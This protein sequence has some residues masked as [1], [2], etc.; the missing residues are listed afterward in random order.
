M[1]SSTTGFDPDLIRRYDI[2]GPRYTSYPT[3]NLFRDDFPAGE[4]A[5]ALQRLP[6]DARLSLYLH[7]PFCATVCYYCACNKIITNNRRHAV[8]YLERLHREMA[9]ARA[10]IPAGHSVEQLHF[11]GGTPTYLTDPQFTALF[12]SLREHFNLL[13]TPQRDFSIEI[14]PRTVD[15]QRI[16]FL[17]GLGINRVSLGIQDFDPDVQ[18]AVNR[19]QSVAD[20]RA[21]IDAARRSGVESVSVDLIYGLPLQS[22]ASFA[23]TLASV[24]DLAPDRISLYSYAHLPQRFKTQ[25]QINVLDLPRAEIK[26]QLLQLAIDTLG[27]AGYEY[28][29]MDHF[30]RKDDSLVAAAQRGELQRNFQGY[31]THRHCDLV[32]LGVSA[33]SDVGGV[34]AQNGKDLK[35]YYELVDAGLLPIERGLVSSSEDALRREVIGELMCHFHV[36]TAAV[37]AR[38]GIDFH[39]HFA[40]AMAE[41]ER[42]ERD[43]L[44][45]VTEA[46]I[47]V[48]ARG[49]FLIRNVCMPFD[50][51]LAPVSDSFS[52]A[53]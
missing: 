10:L 52:K 45:E 24:I 44:V 19:I 13:D 35:R 5:G 9:L 29:G 7:V 38:H 51:Y 3:A 42:L 1:T 43:G 28:I 40:D 8:E 53:I 6:D 25:R 22:T 18:A 27:G 36:D 17:T 12:A 2:S 41:L 33:I 47:R 39:E 49:R 20:T 23:R 15:P 16:R 37:S 4:Y 31:T 48:T 14:D 21:I 11:G 46:A 32:A 30:A 50:A 26:L 34:Y